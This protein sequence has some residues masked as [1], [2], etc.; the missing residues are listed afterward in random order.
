MGVGTP[1][2]PIFDMLSLGFP[3][4]FPVLSLCLTGGVLTACVVVEGLEA[5]ICGYESRGDVGN[6][7]TFPLQVAFWNFHSQPVTV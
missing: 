2:F 6:F 1:A 3:Y 5:T 4:A 7:G